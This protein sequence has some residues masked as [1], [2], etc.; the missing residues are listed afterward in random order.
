MTHTTNNPNSSEPRYA[1]EDL[2]A[3]A[4]Q[5]LQRAGLAQERA[6]VVADILVEGDLMGHTTHGLQLLTPY[7]R[8]L[9]AGKMTKEG[10]PVLVAD[11]GAAIT[12]DGRYLPGPWLT[13]QA[14]DL[15][16]ERIAQ[17]PIVTIVIRQ[18]HHIGSLAS[19]PKRATDKG[20]MLLLTCSDP[21][22]QTVA[23]YGGIEPIYTPNPLAAGIPTQGDPILLDISMSCTANGLVWRLQSQ[24]QRLPHQWLLDNQGNPSDDPAVLAT[25]PPGSILPLGGMDVGYKGF[26]LGILVEALT[27]ALGGHGRSDQPTQWGA[28]TFL[29][30]IDPEA[31]GG[32]EHFLRETSWFADTCRDNSTK[33]GNPPVRLPGERAL[34]LRAEQLQQGVALYPTILPALEAWTEK[35]GVPLPTPIA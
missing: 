6:Q 14:M 2:L 1:V 32:R 21:S 24:G 7:L 17:H 35:F 25:E 20:L 22:V 9:E 5:L 29:Q 12:W 3:F 28:S 8:D 16:F 13:I 34:K 19:Y 15:A 30:L 10:D 31:F 27:A 26:A 23:P 33:P 18:S 11:Q 4:A